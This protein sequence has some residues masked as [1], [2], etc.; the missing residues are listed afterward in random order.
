MPSY[1]LFYEWSVDF[2]HGSEPSRGVSTIRLSKK[3]RPDLSVFLL[4][5]G[6]VLHP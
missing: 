1:D 2:Y 5:R 4:A 6:E 3:Q